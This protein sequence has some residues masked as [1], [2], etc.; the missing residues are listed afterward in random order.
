MDFDRAY[1]TFLYEFGKGREMVLSTSLDD[2]VTS[3][4][5]S[6][7]LLDGKFC[8]QTD[9]N[10][11]KYEQLFRNRNVSL[12]VDNVQI[13]GTCIELGRPAA[14][15]QF[16]VAYR[17]RFPSAFERYSTLE[18]ERVFSVTPTVIR[19]WIYLDGVPHTEVFDVEARSHALEQYKGR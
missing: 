9:W 12:C 11:R 15:P 10:S 2:R 5:M 19:R 16:C 13:E 8:F 18:C 3:R 4:M 6:V 7:V 17:E 14:S 1:N